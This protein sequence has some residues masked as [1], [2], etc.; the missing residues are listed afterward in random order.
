M[1]RKQPG[2]SFSLQPPALTPKPHY[3]VL[4]VDD[5][6]ED[7]ALCKRHLQRDPGRDYTIW[8]EGL[9]RKGLIT[10]QTVRP[11]CILL[12]YR[13]PDIDGLQFLSQLQV[14]TGA[15]M[16]AVVM[17]TGAGHE[18][19]AIEAMKRGAQDYLVKD[20]LTPESLWRAVGNAIKSVSLRRTLE[21]Q[22][23][24]LRESEARFRA[25]VNAVPAFVWE[26]APDGTMTLVSE[27]WEH[28]CGMTAEQLA[29]DWPRL[30]LHPDDYERCTAEWARAL[31]SGSLYEV[32]VRNRRYDGEYHW[33][34]T[35]AVPARD[36][37]GH[38]MGWYG[39][40]T[41]IHDRKQ[42]EEGLRQQ[43]EIIDHTHDAVLASDLDG[44]VLSWNK[45]AE[46]LFG[47]TAEEMIGQSVLLLFPADLRAQF[48]TLVM[49]PLRAQGQHEMETRQIRKSGEECYIHLSLSLRRDQRGNPMGIIG[50]GI[51]ITARKQAEEALREQA[52]ELQRSNEELQQF[53]YVASHDLQEPLRMVA[54]FVDLLAR[55]YQGHLDKE[56]AEFIGYAL[57]GARR[58]KALIDDLLAYS[59]VGTR[60][61]PFVPV[62]CEKVL[63]E[64]LQGLRLAVEESGAVITHDPLPVVHAG[65]LEL[66][67]LLQNLLSNALKFRNAAPPRVHLSAQQRGTEWLFS[68][69][70]HGIGI[71]PQ[72]AERI[73]IIFQRLH[74]REEYPGTGIGLAICKKIVDRHGGRVWVESTL[75]RGA[76]FFFTLP[77]GDNPGVSQSSS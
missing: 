48:P 5:S 49:A 14:L 73:F 71:D 32:E 13:F 29:R 58:M 54:A 22:H 24:Q 69:R 41:D 12:D 34:L 45:G 36:D 11:D 55:R 31:A 50:Y 77:A 10:C 70:D 42:A 57:D 8:E 25:L 35:R 17:L 9:S 40:T 15:Q 62:D 59:R 64:T 23:Q 38:I 52:A 4:I 16:P 51:D 19:V 61:E 47:Y 46:R 44:L 67:L 53:A 66:G 39:T 6:P 63:E 1:S 27:Q 3:K 33:F 75:G 26:A 28:Y 56:A 37:T 74:T 76:T 65:K 43:A 2:L 21:V 30:V 18:G 60:R 7:R 20:A 68:V 72:H